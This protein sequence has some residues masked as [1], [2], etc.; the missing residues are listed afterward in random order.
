MVK[1]IYLKPTDTCNLDCSHCFTSGSKGAKT[2]WDIP[3]VSRWVSDLSKQYP[4]DH[5]HVELHGGE[6]FLRPIEEHWEFAQSLQ[7]LMGD[8]YT[9][10]SIGGTT[11]LVYKLY[12]EHI[13]FFT[14]V[15]GSRL[16]TSWDPVYRFKNDRM[17][18]LWKDNLKLLK[19]HGVVLKM[20]VTV[21]DEL[22][23]WN[24]ADLLSLWE[25]FGVDEIAIERLTG[26]GNADEN[27]Y[28]FP[29]NRLV[30]RFY[31][32]LYWEYKSKRPNFE[33]VT[34]DTLEEKFETGQFKVDTNCRDCEQNLFTVGADGAIGGCANGAQS[35]SVGRTDDPV[36]EFLVSEGRLAR[37]TKELDYPENCLTC[38]L[39]DV[40]G[41]DCHRLVWQGDSC[42]GLRLL[43]SHFKYGI[44]EDQT[45]A[46]ST[47]IPVMQL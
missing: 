43:L 24:I 18:D 35:E 7:T 26:G 22:L 10:V 47:T 45:A 42:P 19:S 29:D 1:T 34:L 41:G 33:I 46:S 4:D 21:T 31:Y 11:N 5:I 12:P 37:I 27:P 13:E 6:P 39:F 28:L 2:A 36:D 9:R 44:A 14:T 40:C 3:K 16:G 17:Y 25:D 38:D 20:F 32:D 15:M 8:D 23:N 30:D